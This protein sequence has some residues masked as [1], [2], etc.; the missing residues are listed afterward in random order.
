MWDPQC[1]PTRPTFVLLQLAEVA[2]DWLQVHVEAVA[3]AQQLQ[4]MPGACG[5]PC[6]IDQLPGRGQAVGQN[7]KLLALWRKSANQIMVENSP[8][9]QSPLSFF[10]F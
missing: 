1:H 10:F 7:L 5:T 8:N 2:Q 9:S 4:E 6:V 3:I